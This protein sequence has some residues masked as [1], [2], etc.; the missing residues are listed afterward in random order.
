[1]SSLWAL[2][3]AREIGPTDR[4]PDRRRQIRGPRPRQAPGTRPA[5]RK[6]RR[7]QQPG[8]Y[9]SQHGGERYWDGKRWTNHWRRRQAVGRRITRRRLAGTGRIVVVV[10]AVAAFVGIVATERPDDR[11]RPDEK[12]SSGPQ[13]PEESPRIGRLGEPLLL[14]QG[15]LGVMLTPAR[16]FDPVA[17][18]L[19]R[20]RESWAESR[21]VVLELRA[22]NIGQDTQGL[23]AD[24]LSLITTQGNPAP[25]VDLGQAG[26]RC[27]G[28][29]APDLT[30]IGPASTKTACYAF[31]VEAGEGLRD[32]RIV[33]GEAVGV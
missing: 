26:G 16:I 4:A 10:M 17:L 9:E 27:R 12:N 18:P 29:S 19:D 7:P 15:D 20:R 11:A 22:T 1:M 3:T 8:W 23:N 24:D 25:G 5:S 33:L 32:M 14:G 21:Y 2:A 31:E 13:H 6:P 30:R 28:H